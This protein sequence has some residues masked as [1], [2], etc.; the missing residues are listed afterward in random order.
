MYKESHGGILLHSVNTK[1]SGTNITYRLTFCTLPCL[2]NYSAGAAS[3][4]GCPQWAAKKQST[5]FSV[6]SCKCV[7]SEVWE[8]EGTIPIIWSDILLYW[9]KIK[10]HPLLRH[11]CPKQLLLE[12]EQS[13]RNH[14]F[15]KAWP[16]PFKHSR[17]LL[18]AIG[19]CLVLT[20]FN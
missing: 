18:V 17:S 4:T 16:K 15:L 5:C 3:V 8:L 13:A 2:Y 10:H 12:L 14:F 20:K 1:R 7:I 19:F 11:C 6:W 9:K